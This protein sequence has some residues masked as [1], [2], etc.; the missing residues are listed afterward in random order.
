MELKQ[1]IDLLK[2]EQKYYQG[3]ID[4]FQR[5]LNLLERMTEVS[6]EDFNKNIDTIKYYTIILK[7]NEE[8][9]SIKSNNVVSPY[10]KTLKGTVLYVKLAHNHYF[11][12][13]LISV[14][15]KYI[16]NKFEGKYDNLDIQPFI[17]FN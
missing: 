2:K 13:N 4:C 8:Y 17:N 9:Q 14:L 1:K 10:S 11:S 5:D 3:Y 6:L 15:T 12:D 16:K 7:E